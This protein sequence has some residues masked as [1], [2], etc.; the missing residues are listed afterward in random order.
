MAEEEE[1]TVQRSAEVPNMGRPIKNDNDFVALNKMLRACFVCRLVKTERQFIEVGCDN[2]RF[3]RMEDDGE[4]VA[5]LTTPNFTGMIAAIAPRMSWAAKWERLDK[6]VAGCYAL[7]INEDPPPRL[8]QQQQQQQQ[9][10]QRAAAQPQPAQPQAH[11]RPSAALLPRYEALL[12]LGGGGRRD[13]PAAIAGLRQ[14]A[15]RLH[16]SLGLGARRAAAAPS[17]AD[18]E[19][20]ARAA[21]LLAALSSA[22]QLFGGADGGGGEAAVLGGAAGAAV[23]LLRRA[24]EANN[25]E[26]HLALADRYLMGRGLTP[27]CRDGLAHLRRA[28]AAVAARVEADGSNF[29]LP[30]APVRLRERWSDAAAP[31]EDLNW[32]DAEDVVRLEEDA[33]FRGDA[34][35]QRRLGYRRLVGR[36]VP[37]DEAAAYRAFRIA[38]EGGDAM[39]LYNLGYMHLNG[40][41]V[42]TDADQARAFFERAAARGLAAGHT[43]LGVLASE[44]AGGV[45]RNYTAA[46]R[47]FEA[48]AN[49]S[50]ADAMFNLGNIYAYGLG[51]KRDV[52]AALKWYDRA[53]VAGHWRSPLA[54]ALLYADGKDGIA[55]DCSEAERLLWQFV[56]ERSAWGP[57]LRGALR[58]LDA[59]RPWQALVRYLL[60]AEQGCEAAAANAAFMLQRGAG[61]RGGGTLALALRLLHRSS[62]LNS[63]SSMVDLAALLLERPDL[64]GGAPGGGELDA[65]LPPRGGETPYLDGYDYGGGAKVEVKGLVAGSSG[66]GKGVFGG[67]AAAGGGGGEG[68]GAAAATAAILEKLR[69]MVGD[70]N[71]EVLEA[72]GGGE[73]GRLSA[74]VQG[75]GATLEFEVTSGGGGGG[76]DGKEAEEAGESA[77]GV[78]LVWLRRAEGMGDSEASWHLAWLH[79]H[80]TGLPQDARKAERVLKSALKNEPDSARAAVLRAASALLRAERWLAALAGQGAADAAAAWLAWLRDASPISAAQ[81][82]TQ[83]QLAEEGGGDGG[84]GGDG[85]GGGGGQRAAPQQPQQ[86]Q[87]QAQA[88][89]KAPDAPPRASRPRPAPRLELSVDRGA[90]PDGGGGGGDDDSGGGPFVEFLRAIG[91]DKV[92][93]DDVVLTL[94]LGALAAV[95]WL[96]NRQLRG[97]PPAARAA[98]A[99][100]LRRQEEVAAA[101]RR[102]EE[103]RRAAERQQQQEQRQ[104]EGQAQGQQQGGGVE[105]EEEEEQQQAGAGSVSRPAAGAAAAAD[106]AAAEEAAAPQQA[107]GSGSSG[108][109]GAHAAPPG[110]GVEGPAGEPPEQR[111]GES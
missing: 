23:D 43:G 48:A 21:Y 52:S 46:R 95:M 49:G 32:D 27:S 35:A 3:L 42:A 71:V 64:P 73:P 99:E 96:R 53:Y 68:A 28:A 51:V 105:E 102:A 41:H 98:A 36:G 109:G 33:A 101:R 66:S 45:A 11:E 10:Q 81:Y 92:A 60:L 93:A 84:G 86:A 94:M 110:S 57:S 78:A 16:V 31:Q 1:P 6:A 82:L 55:F 38:A 74:L 65:L 80:G 77:E 79:Q 108:G 22:P 37:R 20:E 8:R 107:A 103:A 89:Q 14:L 90:A 19:A 9:Q 47:H 58:A 26:A 62:V 34:Q 85:A 4:A 88:Q 111:A 61:A 40:L 59:G 97:P 54:L 50:N 29:H 15:G 30:A 104:R 18:L 25:T 75:S 70:A 24:A 100:R 12:G 76:G 67:K 56:A 39:A 87:Q 69:G 5:N 91:S 106:D 7:A 63:T 17:A 44:G 2:C 72:D 83:L 13:V